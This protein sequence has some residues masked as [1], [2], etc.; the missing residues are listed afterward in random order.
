MVFK[1][2]VYGEEGGGRGVVLS[3]EVNLSST[4]LSPYLHFPP[5]NHLNPKNSPRTKWSRVS[6]TGFSR[7][8]PWFP[9]WKEQWGEGGWVGGKVSMSRDGDF[10]VM[11]LLWKSSD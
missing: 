7:L 9:Q 1:L 6:Q 11:W 3:S 5:T 10:E 4:Y 2:P 8:L